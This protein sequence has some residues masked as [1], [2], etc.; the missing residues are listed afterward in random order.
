[1]LLCTAERLVLYVDGWMILSSAQP[2]DDHVLRVRFYFAEVCNA[3]V[4]SRFQAQVAFTD[5]ARQWGLHGGII[6]MDHA[7]V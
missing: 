1:M 5:N 2:T 7:S 3:N 4:S 6:I